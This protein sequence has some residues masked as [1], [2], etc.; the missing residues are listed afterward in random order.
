M[1]PAVGQ[2][3][4]ESLAVTRG[5]TSPGST[6]SMSRSTGHGAA[7]SGYERQDGADSGESDGPRAAGGGAAGAARP[8][9]ARPGWGLLESPPL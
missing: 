5:A 4:W 8:P 3:T 1:L 6:V 2:R 7:S 9:A